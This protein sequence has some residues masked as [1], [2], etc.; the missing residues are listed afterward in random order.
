MLREAGAYTLSRKVSSGL[1]VI[2]AAA[3]CVLGV[4]TAGQTAVAQANLQTTLN[5]AG[6]KMLEIRSKV[7]PGL[8]PD[9]VI[10]VSAGLS[11]VDTAVGL[12]M[13]VDAYSGRRGDGATVPL[14]VVHGQLPRLCNLTAGRWPGQGEAVVSAAVL[15]ILGLDAAVGYLSVGSEEYPVVGAFATQDPFGQFSTGALVAASPTT[16]EAS[17]M[18]VTAMDA[19]QSAWVESQ[20]L[21]IVAAPNRD[22]IQVVSPVSMAELQASINSGF[23]AYANQVFALIL[24]LGVGVIAVVTLVDVLLLRSDLGRRRALGATRTTIAALVV[25]RTAIPTLIGA[26]LGIGAGL[27]IGR[28]RD[29]W[30]GAEFTLALGT[31][32]LLAALVASALPAFIAVTQD[33]VKAL[34]TP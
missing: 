22:Q 34:R 8:F 16:P 23:T 14:W 6:S 28:G 5:A 19:S 18:V 25:L 26:V 17:R 30:P 9:A 29:I 33:P 10:E 11:A 27:I 2:L 15:G 21:R 7:G 3:I 31:V 1:I 32:C 13:A 4:L 20:I 24:G 12:A